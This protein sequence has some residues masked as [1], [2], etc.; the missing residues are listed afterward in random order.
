[1]SIIE[2]KDKQIANLKDKLKE[3]NSDA[4]L[5]IDDRCIQL[6]PENSQYPE[7]SNNE[8]GDSTILDAHRLSFGLCKK[9][10]NI[11]ENDELIISPNSELQ[12]H[13][14]KEVKSYT[15]SSVN[16]F[17]S[18]NKNARI[19]TNN[20]NVNDIISKIEKDIQRKRRAADIEQF[21]DY[22]RDDNSAN[23]NSNSVGK[24][25]I[26]KKGA[27]LR[28][29]EYE[30]NHKDKRMK[31]TE[32]NNT[33]VQLH[34]DQQPSSENTNETAQNIVKI[35]EKSGWTFKSIKKSKNRKKEPDAF[36]VFDNSKD[37]NELSY[38]PQEIN[39]FK[40]NIENSTTNKKQRSKKREKCKTEFML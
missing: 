9:L 32:T 35:S 10:K 37:V 22:D 40:A 1:L 17:I 14:Q 30:Y 38:Q 25:N 3:F 7:A 29:V 5:E 16:P 2:E 39:N 19:V 24:V 12:N 18:P 31:L 11:N 4:I 28:K 6:S 8:G 36:A 27:Q 33:E 23:N 20:S 21:V 15:L 34:R 13:Q 26:K